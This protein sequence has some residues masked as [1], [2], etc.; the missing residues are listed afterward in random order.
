MERKRGGTVKRS[1]EIRLDILI[2]KVGNYYSAH[3][4]QFDIVTTDDTLKDVQKTIIDL[5]VAHIQFSQ[6]NDNMDYL[7]FPAPPE[8]WSEYL[9]IAKDPS[10]LTKLK[11]IKI[12]EFS[13]RPELAMPSFIAQEILCNVS[14]TR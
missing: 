4:L 14:T 3:C 5:C 12:P 11:K 6:D 9:T 8:V 2:K 1:P 10:C 13:D 7:F